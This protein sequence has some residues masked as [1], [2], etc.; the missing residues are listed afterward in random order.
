MTTASTKISTDLQTEWKKEYTRLGDK[1][2]QRAAWL[3]IFTFPLIILANYP[4]MKP[5]NLTAYVLAYMMPSVLVGLGLLVKHF[6]PYRHE[7]LVSLMFGSVFFASAFRTDE[8]ALL[9]YLIIN[10]VSFIVSSVQMLVLPVL[11]T[12]FVLYIL[13]VHPLVAYFHYEEALSVYLGQNGGVIMLVLSFVFSGVNSLR[14]QILKRNFTTSLELKKSY[15]L[16]SQKTKI[17]EE[18][19]A[20][21]AEQNN[22]ITAS[23][24]YAKRIQ[25]A[26]LPTLENIKQTLPTSFILFRPRDIVSGDFYWFACLKEFTGEDTFILAAVDC[27]GHGVPGAFMSMIG[28]TFL[29]Q[30][31]NENRT[32]QPDEILNELHQNIQKA[33]KQ[34]ESRN[35][36]G[37]DTALV[38]VNRTRQQLYFTGAKNPLCYVQQGEFKIIK[39]DKFSIGGFLRGEK[40]F[41]CHRLALD[42]S[43]VFYL[44]SDGFQ[45]QFGGPRGKK[46]T[47]GRF[48]KLLNE[49]HH[50]PF[51]QQKQK[52]EETLDFWQGKQEQIDDILVVG[53][54]P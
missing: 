18:N 37:M 17:I 29:N 14:Y 23:I 22:A 2:A 13:V 9:I 42:G 45:D 34:K 38:Y 44:F 3:L 16:L 47:V 20:Q 11:N 1:Y 31:V 24:T 50:L 35:W 10:S 15:E 49:L 36:D 32:F 5:D 27:T 41:T 48:Y 40:K 26:I 19:A 6:R 7:I 53:F 21:L 30:I 39:A 12:Y 28:N 46:F 4:L 52:L 51:S 25:E 43:E 8:N 33:L 54:K